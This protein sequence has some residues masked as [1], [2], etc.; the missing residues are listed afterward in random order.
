MPR[1]AELD[2]RWLRDV[3]RQLAV[4]VD[5]SGPILERMA[6]TLREGLGAKTLLAYAVAPRGEGLRLEWFH[7]ANLVGLTAGTSTPDRIIHEVRRR[8]EKMEREHTA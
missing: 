3:E 8:L 4:Y 6:D 5:G 1:L 2:V 7:G